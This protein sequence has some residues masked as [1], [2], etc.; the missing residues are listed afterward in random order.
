MVR[1][2]HCGC[3]FMYCKYLMILMMLTIFNLNYGCFFTM[4]ILAGSIWDNK[5]LVLLKTFPTQ[6]LITACIKLPKLYGTFLQIICSDLHN[7]LHVVNKYELHNIADD[8]IYIYRERILHG[9][10]KI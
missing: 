2:N 1:V 5:I 7:F 3:V 8:F 10:A 6:V 4:Y 9:G